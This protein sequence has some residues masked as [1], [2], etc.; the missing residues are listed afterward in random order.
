MPNPNPLR[1]AILTQLRENARPRISQAT[2][3][4]VCGLSGRTSRLT[5][6]EWERGT[7]IPHANRRPHLLHYLWDTLQ[8]RCDP[9]Q[10]EEVWQILVEEWM[11]E[12]ISDREWQSL[13]HVPRPTVTPVLPPLST[14]APFQ[15]PALTPYFVGRTTEFGQLATQLRDPAQPR[16]I[17][18]VGMGGIGKTTLAITLAHRLRDHFEDGVLWGHAATSDPFDILNLWARAYGCDFSS[19]SDLQTRATAVRDLMANRQALVVIDDVTS[20]ERVQYLLPNTSGCTVL[21]TTRNEEVAIGLRAQI[22]PV[23]ELLPTDGLS[24]LIQILGSKRVAAE[25]DAAQIISRRLH[26]LPLAIEIAGQFL[27]ARSRRS[28]HD[29]AAH[30]DDMAQRLDLAIADRTVRTSFLVSWEMLDEAHRICFAHMGVFAGRPFTLDVLCAVLA[31]EREPTQARLELLRALSLVKEEG[32]AHYRQHP[33]LADF[34]HEQLHKEES[35]SR[36]A[37]Q[38]MSRYYL[39]FAHNQYANATALEAEWDNV[40]AGMAAAYH[41]QEWPVVVQYAE[42][43]STPWATRAEYTRARSGFAWAMVAAEKT[44]DLT[45]QATILIEWGRACIEQ[46]DYEEA[47]IHLQKGLTIAT[48]LSHLLL[49]AKA[50]ELLSIIAVER[51]D[52]EN[53]D[54]LLTNAEA[55]YQDLFDTLGVARVLYERAFLLYR[56]GDYAM[57]DTICQHALQTRQAIAL[58]SNYVAILRLLADCANQREQYALAENYCQ[59][60]YDAAAQL[61]QRNDIAQSSLSLAMIFRCVN[62]LEAAQHYAERARTMALSIGNRSFVAFALYEESIIVTKMGRSHD[63][64]PLCLESLTNLVKLN[65]EYSQVFCL[66]QLG[67]LYRNTGHHQQA[68][69]TWEQGIELARRIKHPMIE[70]FLERLETIRRS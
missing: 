6:G 3:A 61:G 4:E 20:I 41:Q 23:D 7:A 38:Q 26:H 17:A 10:F 67:D 30:L 42:T 40:M 9:Q 14:P 35:R 68:I 37:Y 63:A 24:L 70:L 21:L 66:L 48:V 32:V 19:H 50:V 18:L 12:P 59:Q 64:L 47:S 16:T 8:L 25:V 2:M 39:A 31:W 13:T 52:Y 34:A 44:E 5:V 57:A 53:A 28:L 65:D 62:K 54:Q 58:D 29:M 15:A 60:A 69:A 45:A 36:Q 56:A 22:Y 49:Q 33:L 46:S 1:L 27:R 11:W 55:L 43:L 51:G